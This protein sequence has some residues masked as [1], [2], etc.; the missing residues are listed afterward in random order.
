MSNTAIMAVRSSGH[1]ARNGGSRLGSLPDESGSPRRIRPVADKM[2]ELP[3]A[4]TNVCLM[5]FTSLLRALTSRVTL[6]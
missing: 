3:A 4:V 1:L 6:A 5:P 2:P